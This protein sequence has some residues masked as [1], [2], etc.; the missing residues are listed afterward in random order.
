MSV[1]LKAYSFTNVL[2][3]HSLA[4]QDAGT[5]NPIGNNII[6]NKKIGTVS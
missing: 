4:K 1:V 2:D 6:P 5:P 3:F